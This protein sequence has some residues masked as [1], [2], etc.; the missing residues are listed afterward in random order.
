MKRL[1]PG[2]ETATVAEMGWEEAP[3][4]D[5]IP[6]AEAEFDVLLTGDKNFPSQQ[7]LQGRSIALIVLAARRNI[8]QT[9]APLMPLVLA[10]LPTVQPGHIYYVPTG[11]ASDEKK[12]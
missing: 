9:M 6:V 3:D 4:G 12:P 5:L 11:E 8:L 1:L 2:H 10:L 7:N